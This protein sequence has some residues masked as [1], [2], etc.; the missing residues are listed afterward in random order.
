[1]NKI[2]YSICSVSHLSYFKTMTDS[3]LIHNNDYKIFLFLIDKI[4]NDF[5]LKLND[6]FTIIEIDKIGVENFNEV[7]ERYNL[8]ELSCAMKPYAANYLFNIH[9]PDLLLYLDT[10]ILVYDNFSFAESLIVENDI[11][12]TPH[13]FSEINDKNLPK[14]SDFLNAGIFNAGFFM[15]KNTSN[16]LAFLN[17]WKLRMEDQCQIDYSN[18]KML[19]QNWLNFV[20]YFF[21]KVSICRHLGYNFAYWNFHERHLDLI[22][23]KYFINNKFPLIFIHISG[24]DLS[25]PEKI[26]RHQNRFDLESLEII[27]SIYK[28]YAHSLKLNNFNYY[29]SVKSS[30]EKKIIKSIGLIK[31]LNK[32]LKTFKFK[33]VKLN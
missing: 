29:M 33:L 11:V 24:F 14:E 25:S 2:L 8:L 5:E 28:N 16:V 18:G 32:I 21:E 19:D 3:F 9:K 22:N 12:L 20:P 15:L 1:M 31:F 30:S 26:S 17:W 23:S 27:S 7:N 10:D 4:N 6:S 13:I